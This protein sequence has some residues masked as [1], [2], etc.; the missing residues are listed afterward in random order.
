MYN[1][2]LKKDD[3]KPYH[4][5]AEVKRGESKDVL[6]SRE[7]LVESISKEEFEEKFEKTNHS[8]TI[9]GLKT[10][11]LDNFK[12]ENM[13]EYGVFLEVISDED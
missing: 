13:E 10:P 1:V 12:F 7:G 9:R 5:I 4:V 11:Y 8:V 2:W 3:K 6:I